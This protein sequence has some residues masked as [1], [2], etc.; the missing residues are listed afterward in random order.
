[1][2]LADRFQMGPAVLAFIPDRTTF[3]AQ[4][5]K[6]PF[7]SQHLLVPSVVFKMFAY[8]Y[9]IFPQHLLIRIF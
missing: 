7:G 5:L 3:C 2:A 4:S 8:V 9:F 6:V 1:M